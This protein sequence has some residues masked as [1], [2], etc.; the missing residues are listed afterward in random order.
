MRVTAER[1][2]QFVDVLL[3]F[4][5]KHICHARMIGKM[6]VQILVWASEKEAVCLPH[7]I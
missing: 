4:F 7:E 2:F 5:S 3:V 6:G 1:S